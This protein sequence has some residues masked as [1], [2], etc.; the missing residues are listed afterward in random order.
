M[1]QRIC[2][3]CGKPAGKTKHILRAGK[4]EEYDIYC[5]GIQCYQD[6][7]RYIESTSSKKKNILYIAAAVF[8]LMNLV[9]FGYKMNFRFMYLP[10]TGLGV[11]LMISPSI[12]VTSWFFEKY[13]VKRTVKGVRLAGAAIVLLGILFTVFWKP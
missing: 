6:M 3:Y 13:G 7:K 1:E 9:I 4:K 5:C 8:V 11:I 12:Y 10:M 2:M